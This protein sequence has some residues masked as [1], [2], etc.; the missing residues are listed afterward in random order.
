MIKITLTI[1]RYETDG[2]GE[3]YG[4]PREDHVYQL[5]DQC[6]NFISNLAE[7]VSLEISHLVKSAL[8]T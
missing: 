5:D 6:E 7:P 3:G 1:E 8:L 4:L 2:S